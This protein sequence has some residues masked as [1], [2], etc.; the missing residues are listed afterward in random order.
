MRAVAELVVMENRHSPS[1]VTF[2]VL[3]LIVN[4]EYYPLGS[5]WKYTRSEGAVDT[6]QGAGRGYSPERAQY[7]VLCSP[8]RLP[9]YCGFDVTIALCCVRSSLEI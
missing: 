7:V 1:I 2:G 6:L 9:S 4:L 3:A 5:L 8:A